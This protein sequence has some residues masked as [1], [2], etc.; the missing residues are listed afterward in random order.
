MAGKFATV[1]VLLSIVLGSF[2]SVQADS[3][4]K[5]GASS[6]VIDKAGCCYYM[7]ATC[8]ADCYDA[9]Q[10]ALHELLYNVRNAGG[11]ETYQYLR[12]LLTPQ[13]H[14]CGPDAHICPGGNPLKSNS[15]VKG[16]GVLITVANKKLGYTGTTVALKKNNT[17][18]LNKAGLAMDRSKITFD[19]WSWLDVVDSDF[20]LRSSSLSYKSWGM[21]WAKHS[22]VLLANSQLTGNN[23][24][25]FLTDGSK[26]TV[27]N[28]NVAFSQT[29]GAAIK[30]GE[31]KGA[32][33]TFYVR[34]STFV[35]KK[36][37]VAFVNSKKVFFLR[38]KL[39][40]DSSVLSLRNSEIFLFDSTLELKSAT[41]NLE[42]SKIWLYN[43]KVVQ[44]KFVPSG[45]KKVELGKTQATYSSKKP[46]TLPVSSKP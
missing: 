24:L 20:T 37:N 40:L 6:S 2:Q 18:Q 13:A 34:E 9:N 39:V 15:A 46:M 27:E 10:Q 22:T 28:S 16:D 26:M 4:L 31:L 42:G 36:S 33:P 44:D 17:F 11:D 30:S 35:A 8:Q 29:S 19:A 45:S 25:T 1:L 3:T 41:V 32:Y 12:V 43:S 23:M 7:S 5:A 14:F 38:S 21:L